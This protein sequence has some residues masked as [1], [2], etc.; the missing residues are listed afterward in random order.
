MQAL[1]LD[2]GWSGTKLESSEFT[3]QLQASTVF[4][5][6]FVGTTMSKPIKNDECNQ[7]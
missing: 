1:N 3:T 7:H 4:L 2:D 6:A 5:Y